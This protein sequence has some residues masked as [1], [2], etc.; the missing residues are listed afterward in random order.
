MMPE[1]PGGRG[2]K[3][4][5]HPVIGMQ[6]EFTRATGEPSDD[7][8]ESTNWLDARM[9]GPP[10]HVHP[11][12]EESF[13]VIV[14]SLDVF[15]N[16]KWTTLRP[17]ETAI[18]PPGVKGTFRNTHDEPAKAVVRIRPAGRSEAFF[19]DMHRLTQEGMAKRFPP[20]E[21]RT[22]IYAAM[23]YDRYPDFIRATG[24]LN[25]VFKVLAF[26]GNALRFDF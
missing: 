4:D 11:N 25:P 12:A 8:F 17:G 6:W 23:L 16:G 2:R 21:P 15:K 22:S 20:K 14:G 18:V 1:P 7:L 9:P 5:N 19:R 13:E 3:F 10:V 24:A 26:V